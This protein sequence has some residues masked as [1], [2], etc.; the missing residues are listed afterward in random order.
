MGA[1]Q[2]R[3]RLTGPQREL[4]ESLPARVR[5]NRPEVK[6]L[7]AHGLAVIRG[8]RTDRETVMLNRTRQGD[9][10]TRP[11]VVIR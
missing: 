7:I 10:V 1:H 4:L 5:P 11:D 8:R 2:V 3:R 6:A 9:A